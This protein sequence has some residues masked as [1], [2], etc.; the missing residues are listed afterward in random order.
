M[1][2]PLVTEGPCWIPVLA[3]GN[4]DDAAGLFKEVLGLAT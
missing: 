1:P 4:V 3:S 2:P